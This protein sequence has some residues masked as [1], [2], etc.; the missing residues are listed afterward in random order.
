MFLHFQA[1][2]AKGNYKEA[3]D[4]FLMIQNDKLK[5]DYVYISHLARCCKKFAW[6]CNFADHDF[7][8]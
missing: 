2:V 5:N 6:Y 8:F 7:Q 1:Q 4:T 3:E